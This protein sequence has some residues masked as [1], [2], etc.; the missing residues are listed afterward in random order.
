MASITVTLT[1]A[2]RVGTS[3]NGNPTW[4]LYTE[5]GIYRAQSDSA[6]VYEVEN[7]TSRPDGP[8]AD[9]SWI[10]RE[11]VLTLTRS[12]RVSEWHLA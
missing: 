8:R 5:Q 3:V 11:V 12:G 7:R 6:L 1:S 10:G 4:D 2:H 9:H